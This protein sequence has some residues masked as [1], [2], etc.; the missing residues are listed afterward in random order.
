MLDADL[1]ISM[2]RNSAPRR[3]IMLI[4]T[5]FNK[6]NGLILNDNKTKVLAVRIIQFVKVNA[7]KAKREQSAYI[8]RISKS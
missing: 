8:F 2:E 4:K 5:I 1:D 7:M 3:L 6:V